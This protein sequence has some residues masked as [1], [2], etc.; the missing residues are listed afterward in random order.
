[1]RPL[2]RQYEISDAD[3]QKIFEASLL[4]IKDR[5]D[6]RCKININDVLL[7]YA[8]VAYVVL[9]CGTKDWHPKI[10]EVTT[11]AA[12]AKKHD[13]SKKNS[14]QLDKKITNTVSSLLTAQDVMIGVPDMTKYITIKVTNYDGDKNYRVI[15]IQNPIKSGMSEG[16]TWQYPYE[17]GD[18]HVV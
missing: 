5:L 1:M 13:I 14:N 16:H 9:A 4:G 17:N 7:L 11:V 8:G 3:D 15:S 18:D 12:T 2:S 6:C 10:A